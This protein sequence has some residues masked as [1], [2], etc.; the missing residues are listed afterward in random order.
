MKAFGLLPFGLYAKLLSHTSSIFLF[1]ERHVS[2]SAD[3][4]RRKQASDTETRKI[5]TSLVEHRKG[6]LGR[7]VFVQEI[8]LDIQYRHW[9]QTE[10]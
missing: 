10:R 1:S 4:T 8:Y 3:M 7:K 2:I 5:I 6:V 9:R